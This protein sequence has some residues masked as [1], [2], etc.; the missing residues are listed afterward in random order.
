[1]AFIPGD[2]ASSC[3][4]PDKPTSPG[5]ADMSLEDLVAVL[6]T[7]KVREAA[8]KAVRIS[9]EERI[10]SKIDG[11]AMGQKTVTLKD[12]TKVTVTRGF[13]FKAECE[14]IQ[15]L[16]RRQQWDHAPPV[17]AK[18]TLK[19]DVPAYQAYAKAYPSVYQEIAKHVTVTEKKVA[20]ELKAPKK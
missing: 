11:P 15:A 20:V 10:A 18:T 4:I 7:A 1:M 9:H 16:F 8:A 14:E 5:S 3:T 17:A 13:N 2:S 19:L 12:G 6:A